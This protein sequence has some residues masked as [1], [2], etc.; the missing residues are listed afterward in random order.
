MA[1]EKRL[2]EALSAVPWLIS[3][4]GFLRIKGMSRA[5]AQAA[6]SEVCSILWWSRKEGI[7][8]QGK[9]ARMFS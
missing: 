8:I 7:S 4:V 2:L 3:M 5:T 9:H 6:L 1:P